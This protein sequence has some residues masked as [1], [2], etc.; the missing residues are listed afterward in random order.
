MNENY[1]RNPR[2][3]IPQAVEYSGYRRGLIVYWLDN[4]L[5]PFEEV[6]TGGLTYRK[7]FI[8]KADLDEFLDKCYRDPAG[9]RVEPEKKE[10]ILLS[11]NQ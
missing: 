8:R 3:S 10:L 9:A 1:K 6:P 2:L 5:L 7:R 11:K 4:G